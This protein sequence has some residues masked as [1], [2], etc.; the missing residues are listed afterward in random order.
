MVPPHPPGRGLAGWLEGGGYPGVAGLGSVLGIAGTQV[1]PSKAPP[2]A[3][4]LDS[5]SSFICLD[6][7]IPAPACPLATW[8]ERLWRPLSWPG[9]WL[10]LEA[11][12]GW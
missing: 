8:P 2:A 6:S 4:G 7:P 9:H 12:C 11:E 5:G 3:G 1:M 10:E